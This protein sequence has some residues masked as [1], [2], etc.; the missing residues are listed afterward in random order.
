M[1]IFTFSIRPTGKMFVASM[2]T[3]TGRF[4]EKR[5]GNF[6]GQGKSSAQRWIDEKIAVI[7]EAVEIEGLAGCRVIQTHKDE[8]RDIT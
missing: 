6:Y 4:V 1:K 8:T 3:P 5:F 7:E 2:K